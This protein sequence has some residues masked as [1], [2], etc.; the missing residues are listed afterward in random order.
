MFH[1]PATDRQSSENRE[2]IEDGISILS[3]YDSDMIARR[4]VS[5][6]KS[7]LDL[8]NR[9]RHFSCP[10]DGQMGSKAGPDFDIATIIEAFYRE[11]QNVLSEPPQRDRLETTSRQF[12]DENWPG[13]IINES[14]LVPSED[15]LLPYGTNYTESLDD[16]LSL[17]TNYLN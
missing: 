5:I 2:F 14:S 6:L 16:I 17:A 4:G 3:H 12:S 11:Y 10:S 9:R 7:M 13:M 1:R 8:E 15:L